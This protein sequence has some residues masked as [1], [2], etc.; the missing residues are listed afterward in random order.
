MIVEVALNLPLRQTFDYLWPERLSQEPQEGIRV[1]VPFGAQKKSAIVV[2]IKA[3]SAF[4]KLKEVESIF[5]DLPLFSEAILQFT[6]WVSMYYY[7]SWGEV[8]NS[9]IPGGFNVKLQSIYTTTGSLS[10]GSEKYELS[11][12]IQ[13]LLE[14]QN[15]WTDQ[16]WKKHKPT[17]QDERALRGWIRKKIIVPHSKLLGSKI[18]PKMERWVRLLKLP[19][20]YKVTTS[21]KK[22][23]RD[24]ILEVLRENQQISFTELKDKVP[25]PAT[26]LRQLCDEGYAEI[27]QK[28]IYRRFLDGTL[29]EIIPFQQ[30]S[31]EQESAYD[32]INQSLQQGQYQTFLLN[33]V[34]GSGKTEVY[35]HAVRAALE[36]GK[37]SLILVPEIALTPQLVNH[38]RSRFGDQ[39]AVLHSGMDDGE[40][41]DEWT[42][43][44]QGDAP[45]VVGARSA[46]FA[47]LENIGLI[48]VD[49]EHDSSYKQ[50]ETPRYQGR[51]I[52]VYRGYTAKATVVL[53]SAT[54]SLE[55]CHNIQKGKFTQLLLPKRVMQATMPEVKLLN[56]KQVPRQKGKALFTKPLVEAL[57]KRLLQK[58]QS[59]VFLNRRGY[60]SLAQC[61]VCEEIITCKNCSLS[62]VFHQSVSMLKC[63]QCDYQTPMPQTCVHCGSKKPL[64]I[65]GV[66]TEQVEKE[67]KE[68]FPE[69]RLLRMDRDTLHG[70]HA[71]SRMLQKI[72]EH[73]VDI[74]IGTQLVTKG[75]D[76]PN[77]TFV[78]VILA[79]ISL[80]IPDFRAA[81]RTYQ[82]ITQVTGRAGRGSKPGEVLIQT[83]NPEHHSLQ[84]AYKHD[85]VGFR[86]AELEMRNQLKWPPYL[87]LASL[88]FSSDQE[89]RAE[90]LAHQFF[91]NLKT[92]SNL[93]ITC[94]GPVEA[95]IKRIKNR[96][97]WMILLKASHVKYLHQVLNHALSGPDPFM[98]RAQDRISVDIDPYHL[99]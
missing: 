22:I 68:M 34:T 94:L 64:K 44:H 61:E 2:K 1:F 57:R 36:Q 8:L 47:P 43:I 74:I 39:V 78:G 81:E 99:L 23:K 97:R 26:P 48:V 85:F 86:D 31:P 54:P 50:E 92:A 79:D 90:G 58:E 71:L 63:H 51:D 12:N 40:R 73:K 3:E 30:L 4:E 80:N 72:K 77:I 42:K 76:F 32:A 5:D 7:C 17:L 20:K 29:P 41:F 88:I 15:T 35:L 9:A 62:L 38:F 33:G 66:G 93:P 60:A 70:K 37:T 16:E 89:L 19:E 55:A 59:I 69:A 52:A 21:R 65:L 25:T 87:N 83:Y 49:E 84:C 82:L 14:K 67:L 10:A 11:P 18:T 75:H 56:L 6:H 98:L 24:L 13:Q 91:D 45:I 27:F 95:P 53:G 96:F 28:R 46:I